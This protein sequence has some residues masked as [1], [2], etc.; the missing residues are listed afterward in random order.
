MA[1]LSP[2]LTSTPGEPPTYNFGIAE[3]FSWVPV[4]NA[5]GR[6]LFA[7]AVYSVNRSDNHGQDGFDFLQAGVVYNTNKYTAIH[8]ITNTTFAELS[9]DNSSYGTLGG[10][11]NTNIFQTTFPAN[12]TLNGPITHVKLATGAAIGYK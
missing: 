5:I 8:T 12:F 1:T 9:S 7:K 11:A 10:G 4:G 2:I 3:T 6:P